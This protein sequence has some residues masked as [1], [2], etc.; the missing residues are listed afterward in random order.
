MLADSGVKYAPY[1]EIVLPDELA[2]RVRSHLTSPAHSHLG[3]AAFNVAR[4]LASLIPEVRI[5]FAGVAGRTRGG[6]HPHAACL[7]HLGVDTEFLRLSEHEPA[8]SI[9]FTADGDR[10]LLTSVGTSSEVSEYLV[11]RESDLP[12][13]I[14][15][16]EFIH[17]SSILDPEVPELVATAI[18]RA[19][20]LSDQLVVSLDPG[21]Y[22]AV[23]LAPAAE[24]LIGCANVLHLNARQLSALGGQLRVEDEPVVAD[25]ILRLMRTGVRYLVVRRHDSASIFFQDH[26]GD[27]YVSTVPSDT[28]PAADI[29]DASGAG[30]TFTAG[31]LAF[32]ASPLLRAIAGAR[33]GSALAGAKV[34]QLG[35]LDGASLVEAAEQVAGRVGKVLNQNRSPKQEVSG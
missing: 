4:I 9:G 7:E 28:V 1:G 24:R 20:S 22:W 19:I 2:E 11:S 23:D 26:S 14:S 29:M 13:Y 8:R 15:S 33:L 21:H 5:G 10:T 12:P 32:L 18:E 34:R 35:P 16:F 30:A 6:G 17:I 25:R 27:T 3:G 31:F